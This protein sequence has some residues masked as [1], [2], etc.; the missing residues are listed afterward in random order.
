MSSDY[1]AVTAQTVA[2]AHCNLRAV[3]PN[4]QNAAGVSN[5]KVAGS[6]GYV[7]WDYPQ[8][9]TDTGTGN[10]IVGCTYNGLSGTAYATFGVGS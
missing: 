4:G 2:G 8:P 7:G 5:P 10:H 1:G 3:L 9:G 6:G